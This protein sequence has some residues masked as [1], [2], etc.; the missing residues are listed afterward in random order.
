MPTN[1]N[2]LRMKPFDMNMTFDG[3]REE[4]EGIQENYFVKF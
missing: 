3:G 4:G 2:Y 1:V